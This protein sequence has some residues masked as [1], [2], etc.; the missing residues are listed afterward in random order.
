[1]SSKL[2]KFLWNILT[3]LGQL[4]H[5][6]SPP[7]W[8]RRSF[9]FC[10]VTG[11]LVY[12][13]IFITIGNYAK[14]LIKTPPTQ[15]ADTALILGNRA[16][17][18]DKPNPCL[19]GRVDE[20]LLLAQQGIVSTLLMSG[21]LD[22]ED[23]RIEARVMETHARNKG[24]QGGI[25][26]ESRSSST[27]ENLTFSRSILETAGIKQIIITSEPYHMWRVKKLVEAGHMGQK[28]NVSYAAAPSQ[29]WVSWGMAFKGAL[30]E[31]LAVINN[32]VK[33]Y[34]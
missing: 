2:S 32:Y 4:L 5:Q 14:Q 10:A 21:G 24:F 12:L 29:C 26:V 16:Y 30:R 31:P 1:M 27:L 15:K 3:G 6:I 25:L 22:Y 8:L 7:R 19:T 34:F 9:Y 33:G 13:S 28:I 23:N 20:G 11:A 17:L 18:N